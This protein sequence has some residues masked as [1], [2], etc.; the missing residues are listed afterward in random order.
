[1]ILNAQKKSDF[2]QTLAAI[3]SRWDVKTLRQTSRSQR[4]NFLSTG[5]ASLDEVLGGG[6][7]RGRVVEICGNPTS[8]MTTLTL[9]AMAAAQQAGDVA[10]YIDLDANFDPDYATHYGV[11]VEELI[12]A[13]PHTA[14]EGVDILLDAVAS[15]IPGV[16]VFNTATLEAPWSFPSLPVVVRRLNPMLTNSQGVLFILR[17]PQFGPSIWGEIAALR[18][19]IACKH[20]LYHDSDICGCQAEV[21]VLKSNHGGIGKA[22]DLQI[23][24]DLGNE[25]STR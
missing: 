19:Q 12:L 14:S 2:K 11:K 3:Q 25:G 18:L 21:T 8:G 23:E 4:R 1:M 20:W 17:S 16:I 24:F 22:V 6:Y 5:Y 10:V 13:R 9:K 15:Q 7:E